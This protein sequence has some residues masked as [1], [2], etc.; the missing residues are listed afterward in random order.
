MQYVRFLD[1]FFVV[2]CQLFVAGIFPN[3]KQLTTNNTFQG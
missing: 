1:K 2:G 3:N